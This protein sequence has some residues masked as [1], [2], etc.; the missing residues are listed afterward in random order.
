M[1]EYLPLPSCIIPQMNSLLYLPE[2]AEPLMQ[3]DPS[4]IKG[5]LK[6]V[7]KLYLQIY[8]GKNQVLLKAC[9]TF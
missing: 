9:L 4:H 2:N 1:L 5:H 7:S 3:K 8:I 6:K